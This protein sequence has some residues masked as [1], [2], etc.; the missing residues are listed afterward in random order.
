MAVTLEV[1]RRNSLLTRLG[2]STRPTKPNTSLVQITRDP[3]LPWKTSLDTFHKARSLGMEVVVALDRRSVAGSLSAIRPLVDRVID[4]DNDTG[5][6][7]GAWN[8]VLDAATRDWAFL[9]SD[10]E[11]PSEALWQFATQIPT[12]TN[13]DEPYIWRPRMLAPLPDW[14]ALYRPLDTYQPRYFPRQ[15]LRHNGGFDELP[16]TR[17]KQQ[18][19]LDLPLWHFTLWS[20]RAYREQK[21][22]DHEAAWQKF[23]HLHPWLPSSDRAYLWENYPDETEP[24]GKWEEHRPWKV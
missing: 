23:W 2:S 6:P 18:V 13:G 15:S 5:W 11:T 12:L 22:R 17:L 10:D 19:N 9:V 21:V 24:I 3:L 4:F 8:T 7:E 20:P 14:S 1:S 16:T